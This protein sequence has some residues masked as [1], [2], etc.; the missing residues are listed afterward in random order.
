MTM[1][2]A[3]A[4]AT[5]AANTANAAA[6]QPT[7]GGQETGAGLRSGQ[8]SRLLVAR[9]SDQGG[10][11]NRQGVQPQTNLRLVWNPAGGDWTGLTG[12]AAGMSLID[13]LDGLLRLLESGE[14]LTEAQQAEIKAALEDLQ[15]LMAALFGI[16]IPMPDTG[17]TAGQKPAEAQPHLAEAAAADADGA[18]GQVSRNGLLETIAFVRSFLA[19]GA[20]RPLDRRENAVFEALIGRLQRALAKPEEPV[21]P[22]GTEHEP[23][24]EI[25]AEGNENRT[26]AEALLARLARRPMQASVAAAVTEAQRQAGVKTDTAQTA[27]LTASGAAATA[28]VPLAQP[29][30]TSGETFLA[31]AAESE[32]TPIAHVLQ[33]QNANA[34]AETART[35][36]PA[37]LPAQTV[38]A[39]KFHE[40]ISGMAVRQMKLTASNG[41]SEARILLVPE[42]LGEVAVRITI[43]NGQLTAQFMTENAL[44]KELIENQIVVLRGALQSQGI[45]VDRLEVTQGNAAS[46]SQMFQEQ[47]QRGGHDRHESGRGKRDHDSL[48]AFESELIEQAAIRELGYGRAINVKA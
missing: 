10:T 3:L 35:E 19:E 12:G 7:A 44:A 18:E 29:T 15:A 38:P 31:T 33:L 32:P 23:T 1:D 17:T 14:S 36:S 27:G 25:R 34:A 40:V 9:V 11:A 20:F 2:L 22:E 6:Q 39:E 16:S 5:P 46:Q 26:S 13:Q 24:V 41:V 37:R 43:Q 21:N 28:D 47:R 48:P 8:F 42:H 30:A 4:F 45:Q